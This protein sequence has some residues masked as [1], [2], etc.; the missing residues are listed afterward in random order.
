MEKTLSTDGD[1]LHTLK[2]NLVLAPNYMNQQVDQHLS[3][4]HF[5][6]GDHVFLYLQF[7]K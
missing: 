7:Y 3:E 4:Y 5:E 1:I 2:D 6:E